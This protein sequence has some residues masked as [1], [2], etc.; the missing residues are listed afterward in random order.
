MENTMLDFSQFYSDNSTV[1]NTV[2]I[3][4]AVTVVVVVGVQFGY[5][6]LTKCVEFTDVTKVQTAALLETAMISGDTKGLSTMIYSLNM[7]G[8]KLDSKSHRRIEELSSI[9]SLIELNRA[10][11]H[12]ANN[13]KSFDSPETRSLLQEEA[14]EALASAV[15]NIILEKRDIESKQAHKKPWYQNLNPFY[16]KG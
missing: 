15:G 6:H 5:N 8:Y 11:W 7:K 13:G 16:K 3:T 4:A 10:L 1:I 12:K 9:I 14:R 2:A